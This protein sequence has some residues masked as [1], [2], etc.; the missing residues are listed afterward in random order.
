MFE[1]FK[2]LLRMYDVKNNNSQE[3]MKEGL[4][5][6]GETYSRR[7]SE[8]LASVSQKHRPMTDVLLEVEKYF[9]IYQ[10]DI[11]RLQNSGKN[12]ERQLEKTKQ[13]LE[14]KPLFTPIEVD[15]VKIKEIRDSQKKEIF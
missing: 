10:R 7:K 1:L 2:T 13:L 4:M 6:F 8:L 5:L 14:Q 9:T 12:L 11:S 3:K 15:Y